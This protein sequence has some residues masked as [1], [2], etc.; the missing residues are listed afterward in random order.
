MKQINLSVYISNYLSKYLP[1]IA[2]LSTNT[3]LS[4]RDMFRLLITFYESELS[5]SP[6]KI[7]INNLNHD[8]ILNFLKWLE[9]NRGNSIS[10]RNIRLASIHAFSRYLMKKEPSCMAEIQKILDI[11]YKK[12]RKG[13]IEYIDQDSM[14]ILL[15]L[16]DMETKVG[17]RDATLLSLLYDTGCRVQELCDLKPIDI[18]LNTPA[19]IKITG[20]GNKIRIVPILPSMAKLLEKYME[21]YNLNKDNL[22]FSPL[23]Q[24]RMG[25]KLTRKGVSYIVDKYVEIAKEIRKGSF[26]ERFTP[27]CFR[28]SKSMHLLQAGVN[29]I[30][31]RDLLGHVD[32]KTTEIY[33]RID[34]EMKRKALEKGMNIIPEDGLPVW[35]E[36]KSLL[37]WLNSLG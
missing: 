10:T 15:E 28:H 12:I 33:A 37:E 11:P 5:I 9:E 13:S 34:G 14:K 4:Y 3:I 19:T 25:E 18:R 2:G 22:N 1:G 29:L 20:K 6:E 8:N 36:N 21:S 26:P 27:H 32:V 30:Y 31:I 23:F 17:L 35:Q 16:P 7:Q 24:N